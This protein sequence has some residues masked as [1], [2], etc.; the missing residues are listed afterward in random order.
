MLREGKCPK[1]GK[2]VTKFDTEKTKKMPAWEI[3]KKYPRGYC[4]NTIVYADSAQY[5]LG[6]Y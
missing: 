4:H 2:V 5:T 3:R 1:C 6:D